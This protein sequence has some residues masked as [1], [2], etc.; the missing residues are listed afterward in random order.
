MKLKFILSIILL[1]ILLPFNLSAYILADSQNA[2]IMKSPNN[3]INNPQIQLQFSLPSNSP[4][5]TMN[6]FIAVSFPSKFGQQLAS[7]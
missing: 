4:G 2:I 3:N 1:S 5:L 6:Q 7:W